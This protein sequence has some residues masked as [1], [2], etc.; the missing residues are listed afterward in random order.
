MGGKVYTTKVV[1]CKDLL[2]LE[3]PDLGVQN[4]AFEYKQKT[5]PKQ[6]SLRTETFY[7]G[8][9]EGRLEEVPQRAGTK[10]R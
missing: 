8:Q 3:Q 10:T 5:N 7:S 4:I 6:M 2:I 9:R 1:L